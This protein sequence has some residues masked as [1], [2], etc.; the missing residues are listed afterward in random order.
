MKSLITK[1]FGI[2]N[3]KNFEKMISRPLANVYIMVGHSLP[4]GTSDVVEDAYDTTQYKNSAFAQGI[5]LK[6]VTSSDVQ[7]VIPRV[8][9][10]SGNVYIAYD[11]TANLFVKTT[12]TKLSGNVNVSAGSTIVYS[13]NVT[14]LNLATISY[15]LTNGKLIT[16][17]EQNKEVYSVNAKGDYLYTN[18]NFSATA[19]AQTIYTLDTSTTQYINKFYVRNS[20][21]QV[22]KC[23]LNNN[24]ATSTVMPEITIG[25]E[26]PEDPYIETS[27]GY[28]W[29]YMYTIPSGL[30]NKFFTD[31]YM[32]VLNES[33][34]YSSATNGRLDVIKIIDGGTGYYSAGSV[35]NYSIAA[36]TG[37]GSGANVTVDVLSGVINNI[38]ILNGG[39]NYS[40]ATITLTDPLQQSSGNTAN[41]Q[42]VISP[43]YG[44]G[45]DAVRELGASD[46]MISVD[47]AGDVGGLLS[48]TADGN[49][50][51]RQACI[52]K[53]VRTTNS[54]V[55]FATAATYAMYTKIYTTTPAVNFTP[56]QRIYIGNSY[57]TATFAATVIHADTTNNIL[58]V[59]D[60]SGNASSV[61]SQ[62]LRQK[63]APSVFAKA[64]SVTS[65][66]INTLSGEILYIENRDKIIRN[67]YQ[68]ETIKLVVE[69]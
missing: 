3:A 63:D 61:V 14:V 58:S 57:G 28:F 43:Q 30:K 23:M 46:L 32:P 7:P 5:L 44:H 4:W 15:G 66:S 13:T 39:K 38:Q 48:V 1:D 68:T 9:W 50:L 51:I 41:I 27:D 11:Q 18:T 21:D 25:G 59:N 35:N 17:G 55:T 60:V 10:G 12:S 29:K 34:V 47:F 33:V 54:N 26:L 56:N 53:D 36:V 24:G 52:V 20:A 45:Y 64:L 40:N 37:D 19:T 62:T 22:F 42:A 16:V 31:K 49:D 65:P 2:T 67:P 8:D 69:F 6:K